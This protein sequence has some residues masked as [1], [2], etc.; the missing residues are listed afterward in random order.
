MHGQSLEPSQNKSFLMQAMRI[1][2]QVKPEERMERPVL[3][4]IRSFARSR[5]NRH[6][7]VLHEC[8]VRD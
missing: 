2:V 8:N 4:G 6:G 7:H 5:T 3:K 1:Q